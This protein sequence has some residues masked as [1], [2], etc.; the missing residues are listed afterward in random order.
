MIRRPPRSTLSSS[1]AAS[2]VYKRQHLY[3]DNAWCGPTFPAEV[4]FAHEAYRHAHDHHVG[5]VRLV[6]LRGGH[7]LG[8]RVR[9]HPAGGHRR[10]GDLRSRRHD[11]ERLSILHVAGRAAT[12]RRHQLVELSSIG[13]VCNLSL[14][15]ISEPTRLLS[16]SYAV[17]CL[18]K[19]KI[20]L[21]EYC[22]Q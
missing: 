19:K 5:C 3:C 14:I 1:S 18:K 16:I 13:P 17:F 7:P 10:P 15:H 6:D 20:T 11:A 2:D 12:V 4:P 8:V 9:P 21:Y 22:I